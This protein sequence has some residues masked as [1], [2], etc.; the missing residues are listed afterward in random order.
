MLWSAH[1]GEKGRVLGLGGVFFKS[2]DPQ[3][4]CEWYRTC[5]GMHIE[6]DF[7]GGIFKL[8][9]LPKEGYTI[10]SAFPEESE[11]FKGSDKGYMMNLL[12]DDVAAIL[13]R[14]KTEGGT[15]AG[16]PEQTEF[17]VFAWVIDPEGNKIEL[18]KP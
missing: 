15:V 5:L 9:T 12:V 10:W 14:V 11:Y 8:E 16:G 1:M 13:D 17:G 3:K 18:W 6:S 7:D 4:L 2:K